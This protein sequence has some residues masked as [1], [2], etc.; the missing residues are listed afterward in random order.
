V[1]TPRSGPSPEADSTVRI[2]HG[3]LVI[4]V[5]AWISA[6]TG[7]D[8]TRLTESVRELAGV[9]LFN[10]DR[11]PRVS[12]D[13][14]V[15]AWCTARGNRL[16][17]AVPL[18]HESPRL[19]SPI[20][21]VLANAVRYGDIAIVSVDDDAPTVYADVTTEEGYW[22]DADTIRITCPDGHQWAWCGDGTLLDD[23][24]QSV[25]R[26]LFGDAPT[27]PVQRCPDCVAYDIDGDVPCDCATGYV[28]ICPDCAARCRLHLP[29]VPRRP[30]PNDGDA[31]EVVWAVTEE[32]RDR[33]TANELGAAI[34]GDEDE[35]TDQD[36]AP[37]GLDLDA[38][39]G[40]AGGDL[41]GL[42]A[43]AR[44]PDGLSRVH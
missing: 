28:V 14:V 27:A 43:G 9:A 15:V 36:R 26:G 37:R 12:W 41:D 17:E 34:E 42:L 21:V 1:S 20:T 24:G 11:Y 4:D 31:I 22:Y 3:H 16:S 8:H 19:S 13:S 35:P 7:G 23:A 25:R 39:L 44:V 32:F 30:S 2:D 40:S 33:F 18:V 38:L 10:Q 6:R 29:D 5:N